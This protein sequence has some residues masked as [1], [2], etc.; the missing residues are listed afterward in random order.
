[1]DAAAAAA[2]DEGMAGEM[3]EEM[4]PETVG[5]KSRSVACQPGGRGA[6]VQRCEV[7]VP[8]RHSWHALT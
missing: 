7:L 3:I 2:S 8:P 5:E 4:R 1:M 6:H